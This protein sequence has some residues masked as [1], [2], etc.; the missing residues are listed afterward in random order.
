MSNCIDYTF[1]IF[2]VYMNKVHIKPNNICRYIFYCFDC[3]DES[4]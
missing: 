1:T 3:Y 4:I 2:H